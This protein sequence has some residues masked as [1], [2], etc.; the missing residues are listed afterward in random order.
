M[1]TRTMFYGTQPITFEN[2]RRLRK[3]MTGAEKILW[4]CLSKKQ[5]N[6]ARFRKQ[7]PIGDY[8]ADFYCHKFK[9]VIE[10]DGPIHDQQIEYDA[11]RTKEM[12][13]AGIKVIRFSNAE[14]IG[15]LDTVV[16]RIK[17]SLK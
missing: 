13:K 4:D 5:L 15:Y 16:E 1:N 6:G 14:I 3:E 10:V 12:A 11:I 2:A 7:H 8:I 9:L 17:I